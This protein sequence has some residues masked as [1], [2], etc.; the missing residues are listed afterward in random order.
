MHLEKRGDY[1]VT[2]VETTLYTLTAGTDESVA[3]KELTVTVLDGGG[4]PPGACS[5]PVNIPDEGL[6]VQINRELGAS[7]EADADISCADLA[8][9]S[10]LNLSDGGV[11][12]ITPGIMQLE[13]LQYAVN[14]ERL[15]IETRGMISNTGLFKDMEIISSLKKLRYFA[16]DQPLEN[17]KFLSGATSLEQF[18][19]T[20]WLSG[21]S[22]MFETLDGLET[23]SELRVLDLT[24]AGD[25]GQ[26]PVLGFGKI[27]DIS[28]LS[29]LTKLEILNL[30]AN[31]VSD[32]TPLLEN[33]GLGTGDIIN[34]VGN[35]LAAAPGTANRQAIEAL[36]A[37]G[38]EVEFEKPEDCVG[39]T[40]I[41]GRVTVTTQAEL[42]NLRGVTEITETLIISTE[43][44]TLDFSPLERLRVV[45]G[46]YSGISVAGNPNLTSISGFSSLERSLITISGN[47]NLRTVAGFGRLREAIGPG[48][49]YITS[50]PELLS[51]PDFDALEKS[52]TIS[53]ADNPKLT[54]LPNFANLASVRVDSSG[55]SIN[56]KNND[57][58]TDL[59]GFNSLSGGLVLYITDNDALTNLSGFSDL[60]NASELVLR[61]NVSLETISGFRSLARAKNLR[62]FTMPALTDISGFDALEEVSLYFSISGI[63]VGDYSVFDGATLNILLIDE[64]GAVELSG[65][66]NAAVDRLLISSNPEL[67][68]I[69]G[70]DALTPG[71]TIDISANNAL[72]AIS[73]FADI[74]ANPGLNLV[75]SENASFDCS[76]QPQSELS[77]L[78]ARTSVGNLV[79]CPV[80]TP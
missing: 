71:L 29:N 6:K 77:F 1:T 40:I 26:C 34:L 47:E 25:F 44:E 75:I 14:L 66:N 51:L 27:A 42:D 10:E 21:G 36:V 17:V 76:A 15:E 35:P 55:I 41:E 43:A 12:G 45:G 80:K 46:E 37:L 31:D 59:S 22:H 72:T 8:S 67:E 60:I 33:E 20:Y 7:R 61:D 48:G 38:A 5:D 9:L 52:F 69:S 65:F 32:L 73:G 2:P 28:A 50:N 39:E 11:E 57:A 30:A 49:F 18:I 23:L 4:T 64:L 54:A 19:T 16:T 63:G 68:V 79:D 13:G 78:P 74:P 53:I 56:I 24:S 70:F 62:L 3:T 58:L